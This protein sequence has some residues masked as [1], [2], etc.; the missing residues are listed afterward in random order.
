MRRI[1]FAKTRERFLDGSKNVT[2][3]NGWLNLKPGDRLLAV[4]KCMGF[5][6]GERPEI[7]GPIEVVDVRRE[8]L[9]MIDDDDVRREG[10]PGMTPAWFVDMF[11]RS[12]GVGPDA[13]VT[14]I[15]F[16]RIT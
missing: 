4:S 10:F 2:R 16:K 5:R 14:R 9:D 8:R 11:C 1:S 12:F 7:Y 13:E 15:E 3:R 6:R